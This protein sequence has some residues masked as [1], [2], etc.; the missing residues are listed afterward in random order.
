MIHQ[1]RNLAWTVGLVCCLSAPAVGSAFAQAS[2]TS[3]EIDVPTQIIQ[4]NNGAV[5]GAGTGMDQI[6]MPGGLQIE[7]ISPESGVAATRVEQSGGGRD[8]CDPS[9][10]DATRRRY[11]VDCGEI[12]APGDGG[13]GKPV[14]GIAHDPLLQPRDEDM[15]KDFESLDLGDDV[16]ATVILQN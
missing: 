13:T 8:L 6:S 10:S 3:S 15:R 9:V 1:T 7:E 12:S 16:P 2:G 5:S 4:G 11:G 14:A